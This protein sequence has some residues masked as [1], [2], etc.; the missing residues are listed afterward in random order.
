MTVT[1][2]ELDIEDADASTALYRPQRPQFKG[3]P[4]SGP[5]RANFRALSKM[6]ELRV[7]V[8]RDDATLL[9]IHPGHYFRDRQTVEFNSHQPQYNLSDDIS[10]RGSGKWVLLGIDTDSAEPGVAAHV[11]AGSTDVLPDIPADIA[12][13]AF[14][15]NIPEDDNFT[16]ED[17]IDTRNIVKPPRL[18]SSLTF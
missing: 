3:V 14:V 5:L 8:N 6:N 11:E 15:K 16:S 18:Q 7:T 1:V 10:P 9:E 4:L 17:I 12:P 2:E 13:V